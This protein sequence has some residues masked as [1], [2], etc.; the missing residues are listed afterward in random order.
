MHI[1]LGTYFL[2]TSTTPL[3]ALSSLHRYGKGRYNYKHHTWDL[4]ALFEVLRQGR[5]HHITLLSIVH[6]VCM[7]E[8][9][10]C[11]YTHTVHVHTR[12]P[13]YIMYIV[14]SASSYSACI[15]LQISNVHVCTRYFEKCLVSMQQPCTHS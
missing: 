2:S 4:Q 5:Y 9:H 1:R 10:E 15:H 6:L 7:L 3:A 12:T 13:V 11:K 8:T 14:H